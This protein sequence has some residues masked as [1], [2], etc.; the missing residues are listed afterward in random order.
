MGLPTGRYG[1]NGGYAVEGRQLGV[2]GEKLPQ[3]GFRLTSP[4]YFQTMEIPLF[5]GRDFSPQDQY[6][7][8][9]VA[10]ISSALARQSFANEDPIGKRI[11]CGLDSPNWMTIVGVVGDVRQSSP[12]AAPEPELYMPLVQHPS[13]A[14]EVQVVVR[15]AVDPRSLTDTLR[16]QVR[17]NHPEVAAR[18]TTLDA[19]V[20]ESIAEHRFRAMLAAIFAGLALILAMAG[21]YGV[22][23]CMVAERTSELGLRMA[24]GAAPGDNGWC[25]GAPAP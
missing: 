8:P 19:M 24:L 5:K 11:R 21:I 23:S 10:I 25:W 12:A 14:N 1:S 3:A 6:D 22:M 18:F 4:A 9:F 13:Y 20:S 2:E 15:T 17:R 16:L 7:S